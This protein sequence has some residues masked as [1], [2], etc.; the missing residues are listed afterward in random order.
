[1]SWPKSGGGRFNLLETATFT[2][3]L[4]GLVAE[5]FV[6][7]NPSGI[8]MAAHIQ[9]IPGTNATTLS[10]AIGGTQVPEP[11]TFSLTLAGAAALYL[12]R[13]RDWRTSG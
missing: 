11:S 13:R 6:Y 2:I 3:A 10:G 1:V 8:A 12:L 7:S 5:D 9:G 4:P